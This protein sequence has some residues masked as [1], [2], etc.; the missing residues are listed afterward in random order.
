MDEDAARNPNLQIRFQLSS[1]QPGEA[2]FIDDIV[3][4]GAV[5]CDGTG[6]VSTSTPSY[7]GGGSYSFDLSDDAGVPMGAYAVCTWDSATP[8]VIGAGGTW[9]TSP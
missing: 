5:Y 6:S 9:F 3:V 2:V 7:T 4:D 8:P 1:N